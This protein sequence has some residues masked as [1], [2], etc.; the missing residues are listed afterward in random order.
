MD[1]LDQETLRK[2]EADAN[3]ALGRGSLV[4]AIVLVLVW[5]GYLTGLLHVGAS[6]LT[7]VNIVFPIII[8][9]L[10]LTYLES[11][12]KFVNDA[13]FKYVLIYSFL[14]SMVV[15]N[16]LIPKHTL[17]GWALAIV[18][19]GHYYN[20]K[21][22]IM[23]FVSVLI[24]MFVALYGG[25]LLGEWDS[26][27]LDAAGTVTIGGQ[28]MPVDEVTFEQR[29][30]YL[31]EL[32]SAGNNRF[33]TTFL[34]YYLP[35]S[36]V[37]AIIFYSTLGLTKRSF[38]LLEDS[39]KQSMVNQRM[40]SELNI[41]RDIQNA[42]L[43]KS[44]PS[45]AKGEIYALMDPAKEVGGDFYDYFYIDETHLACVI[46]DVSGKGVPGALLMMKSEA[47]IKSLATSLG[48]VDTATIITRS[49]IG[50]C[51]NNEA[52]MFVTC[53]FG[54]LNL[55]TGELRYTNAGHTP[56]LIYHNGKVD[57]LRGSIGLVLGALETTI[58]HEEVIQ[59]TKGDKIVLY[60]DGVTETHNK[61][62]VL[63]GEERLVKYA[64]DNIKENSK[65]FISGLREELKTFSE[66][67]DQFD[68]ITMLMLEYRKGAM[69]MESRVFK[70]D[71]SELNNL[72]DYSSSLLRVLDFSNRD[73]IMINTALEEVFVNVAKYAYESNGTVEVSLSNDK[74]QVTF[75]FKDNG[76][77]FNPL[78]KEDPNINA[79]SEEREIGGLGIF[80]VKNIMDKV[81]YVYENGYNILTL[82]KFRNK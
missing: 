81:D 21:V 66:G 16:V 62:N 13:W 38:S 31:L 51:N 8:V 29:I 9:V 40:A 45:T 24:M 57:Y 58:Y 39:A 47:L 79:S 35:R 33:L 22:M 4:T 41:A 65:N 2:N 60:T 59:L 6:T 70:A 46:A 7:H 68:D 5:I 56:P 82:V 17:L 3:R 34:Y 28:T 19:C 12:M 77:P 69:I 25:L 80:M 64:E 32:R 50:L 26:N 36:G 76:K 55:D 61:D 20:K 43:P 54:I 74:K 49:N 67:K 78:E 30:Q 10:V 14:A 44:F 63:F 48:G 73:I 71:V 37:L 23:V 42:V 11:K 53:W 72:F 15:L 75:V 52:N 1:G 27:L 18:I